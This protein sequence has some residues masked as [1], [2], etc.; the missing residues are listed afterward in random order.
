MSENQHDTIYNTEVIINF[1]NGKP[2]T[3]TLPKESADQMIE[4]FEQSEPGDTISLHL[5]ENEMVIQFPRH[6]VVN[7]TVGEVKK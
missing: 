2:M 7:W 5:Q 6:R 4:I 3:L 1:T